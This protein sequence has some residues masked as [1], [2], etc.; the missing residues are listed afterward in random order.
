[1]KLFDKIL[2]IIVFFKIFVLSKIVIFFAFVFSIKNQKRKSIKKNGVRKVIFYTNFPIENAGTQYRVMKWKEIFEQKSNLKVDTFLTEKSKLRFDKYWD[3]GRHFLLLSKSILK[4]F[5]FSFLSLK[6]DA[7]I[8]RRELL[9]FNDYGN[10]FMEKMISALHPNIILDFDDDLSASK[11]E[12]RPIKSL[13]GKILMEDGSKFSKSLK[14]FNRFVVGS[15]YLKDFIIRKRENSDADIAVIPTCVDYNLFEPKTYTSTETMVVGWIGGDYNLHYL[16]EIIEPL[17]KI[18]NQ[19]P[20]KLL[21]IAGEGYHTTAELNFK[22]ENKKWSL[23][24]EKQ[25][26]RLIDIGLM[27]LANT[28]VAKGKCGFKLIQYMGLGVVSIAS[29]ITAN[30]EII[31]D[32]KNGFLVYN[33]DWFDVLNKVISQ[34]N[35]FKEIGKLAQEKIDLNYSFTGNHEK[36]FLFLTSKNI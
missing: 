9:M 32:N 13:F 33:N 3:D 11:R 30:T 23:A 8:I 18:A 10:L 35:R 28:D 31:D 21:V 17:K 36:Y 20:I 5:Y 6:Y 1:M 27:P 26:I 2:F 4:C 15:N 34:R 25:D 24:N 29:A 19:F 22:I 12:P 7:V 14:I 16:N